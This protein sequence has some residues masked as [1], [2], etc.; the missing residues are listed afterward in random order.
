MT[1]KSEL[2]SAVSSTFKS[3]W[4]ERDGKV[5][6]DPSD[7]KLSNDAVKLKATVLYADLAQSTAM[8]NSK[9]VKFSAEIYK[10]FLHCA[11]RIITS[12]GGVITSYDGDRVMGVFIGDSKNSTAARVGLKINWAVRHIIQPKMK[13]TY[14]TDHVVKHTV[15]IDT[16]DLFVARTGIRGSNDLVWVGRSA[17]YAAKLSD[18]TPDIPTWITKAVYDSL[19]ERSKYSKGVDMWKQYKWTQQ[20]DEAVYGSTYEWSLG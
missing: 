13:E 1:L 16:S 7:I 2:E 20:N 18:L 15:G 14:N 4:T 3:G 10:T 11:G 6:P 19:E 9:K 8:V 17:N 12:E 5:V